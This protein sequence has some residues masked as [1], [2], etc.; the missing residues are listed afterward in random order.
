MPKKFGVFWFVLFLAGWGCIAS[1]SCYPNV[2][3]LLVPS[4]AVAQASTLC[5]GSPFEARVEQLK[6]STPEADARRAADAGRFRQMAN[7]V[8]SPFS[9]EAQYP[10][11][12]STA[13]ARSSKLIAMED[14][15][16]AYQQASSTHRPIAGSDEDLAHCSTVYGALL[17]DYVG[18]YN[19]ALV[20][21]PRY[22]H[23]DMCV[24]IKTVEQPK[25]ECEMRTLGS[26]GD[27]APRKIER[28]CFS[29]V[30]AWQ[31]QTHEVLLN[32]LSTQPKAHGQD[33]EISAIDI[34]TA[35]R[36]GNVA[37]VIRFLGS[38]AAANVP[39]DFSATA[40]EWSVI[41]D[42]RDVFRVLTNSRN[43]LPQ[44]FCG[45]LDQAIALRRPGY[46][47]R[48]IP[49]CAKQTGSESSQIRTRI[50]NAVAQLGDLSL[51][52][53]MIKAGFSLQNI[54][55]GGGTRHSMEPVPYRPLTGRVAAGSNLLSAAA[56][57]GNQ[58]LVGYLLA[59]G[60]D[61]NG[62]SQ[63]NASWDVSAIFSSIEA[64]Q[65]RVV[66]YLLERGA[67]LDFGPG[68]N[69]RLNTPVHFALAKGN[70]EILRLLARRG[71][72][73]NAYNGAGEPALFLALAWRA[74]A[75]KLDTFEALLQLGADPNIRARL[76]EPG[77]LEARNSFMVPAAGTTPLWHVVVRG[78]IICNSYE[79]MTP[80]PARRRSELPADCR[81]EGMP[82]IALL[83]A[84]GARS[85][86]S[87]E[88]GTTLVHLL[89]RSDY[90]TE[91]IETLLNH[92]A[93]AG[94]KDALGRTPLDYAREAGS[95]QVPALLRRFAAKPS[96]PN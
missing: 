83:L 50:L 33:A 93:S 79:I 58:R 39:D 28:F 82:W 38:G 26:F 75:A 46:A 74:W 52:R 70:P 2:R 9:C 64:K 66:S 5:K 4:V 8:H 59:S 17:A 14:D 24:A 85:D 73:L 76:P 45:A 54:S 23:W 41:R 94:A 91:V 10:A 6:G 30:P 34:A 42:H 61:I 49:L 7:P 43:V 60:I 36:V 67:R 22:P 57:S 81:H 80:L 32:S 27:L 56:I 95:E 96:R 19:R 31:R 29:E 65:A 86:L 63:S 90:Y 53:S 68:F 37:A 71:I 16:V 20:T 47:A 78:K 69:N 40:L 92:G 84:H 48:L 11:A 55:A 21:H 3:P 62:R 18:R 88:D 35:A 12:L 44:E 72:D 77:T 25:I 51:L 89:A 87:T 1:A 15:D 13:C